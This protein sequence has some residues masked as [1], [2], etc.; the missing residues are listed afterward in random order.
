MTMA[1]QLPPATNP[2]EPLV[3]SVSLERN[4]PSAENCKCD[5]C[6]DTR[7]QQMLSIMMENNW[8]TLCAV[9]EGELLTQM[10]RNYL[11]RKSRGKTSGFVGELT[12]EDPEPE[13][14]EEEVIWLRDIG[15]GN[16]EACD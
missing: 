16:F 12:K 5:S 1:K 8:I 11:R 7:K 6:S 10:L 15:G 14:P 2:K 13:D 3:P 9:C 4:I